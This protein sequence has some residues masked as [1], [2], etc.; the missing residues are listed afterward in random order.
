MFNY[1]EFLGYLNRADRMRWDCFV[2]GYRNLP[3]GVPLEVTDV[4][5]VLLTETGNHK[6][7]VLVKTDCPFQ[8]EEALKQCVAFKQKYIY[9][10]AIHCEFYL[11]KDHEFSSSDTVSSSSSSIETPDSC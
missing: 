5:G 11:C 3:K 10:K 9:K 6:I 1:G 4:F 8:Y 7:A 2:P